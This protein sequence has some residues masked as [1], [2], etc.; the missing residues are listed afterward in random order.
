MTT[1]LDDVHALDGISRRLADRDRRFVARPTTRIPLAVR[2]GEGAH[3]I[4]EDGRRVLDLTSGWNVANAGW[5]HPRIVAA[6]VEQAKELAFAPPWCTHDGRSR[7]AERLSGMLA[8]ASGIGGEFKALSGATGSEAVE[9]ALKVARRATGRQATVGFTEAYH[10]GT[11]GALQAGGVPQVQGVDV[12][13]SQFHRHA[14]IPDMLRANGRDYAA[15]VRETLLSGPP[16]A[17]ILLEPAFTNPGVIHGDREFYQAVQAAAR[18]AGALLIIDEVGTGFG[19]MGHTFGFEHWGLQPDIVVVAKALTS[20]AVPMAGALMRSELADAV[21]GPGFSSTFGWVPLAC[22]AATAS[23]D[24]LEDEQLAERARRLGELALERLRPLVDAHSNV[25]AVRGIGLEL[26]IEFTDAA[27][28]PLPRPPM[29]TLTRR[30]LQRG[31]FAEPSAYTSTLLL[32]PPLVIDE[33][34]WLGALDAIAEQIGEMAEA[35][36]FA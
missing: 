34:E 5:N 18:E 20:G 8:T 27:G 36:E 9:A 16:P 6:V 30:L 33:A 3:L 2:S 24:V 22:A 26:G 4:D 21:S 10:G 17:A 11:L 1:V 19:R 28:D 31:I 14:P 23:L 7:V 13:T 35:G 15:L 25:A 12:P 32:M 29:E